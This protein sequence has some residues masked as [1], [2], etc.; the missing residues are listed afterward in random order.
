MLAAVALVLSSPP[1][2]RFFPENGEIAALQEDDFA[3]RIPI[4]EADYNQR[5]RRATVDS[6]HHAAG[7][8]SLITHLL[9]NR[10]FIYKSMN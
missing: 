4:E 6:R 2:A 1:P 7:K 5:F 3:A 9:K 8:S 10:C